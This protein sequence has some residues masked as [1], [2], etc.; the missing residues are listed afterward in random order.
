MTL[1]VQP[2]MSAILNRAYLG[3]SVTVLARHLP[4]RSWAVAV[5]R[6]LS[7]SPTYARPPCACAPLISLGLVQCGPVFTTPPP[8]RAPA[9]HTQDEIT[10]GLDAAV[11]LSVVRTLRRVCDLANVRFVC[12]TRLNA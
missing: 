12:V 4:I 1:Q 9:S 10:S 8:P 6:C 2:V 7:C 5:H 3:L 11:A